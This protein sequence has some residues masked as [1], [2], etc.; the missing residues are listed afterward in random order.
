MFHILTPF[1]RK[2]NLNFYLKNLQTKNIIWH[3]ITH[4]SIVSFECNSWI[5]PFHIDFSLLPQNDPNYFKLNYFI[6]NGIIIDDDWYCFLNDD[7]WMEGNVI[8]EINKINDYDV[9]FCSMRRGDRIPNSKDVQPHGTETLIAKKGVGCGSIGLE[10]IFIKGKIL[11]QIKFNASS[12]I[13]YMSDGV[14]AEELQN[15]YEVKYIDNI[16]ML[17]NYLEPGRW[18]VMNE[19]AI[20]ERF[21]RSKHEFRDISEHLDTLKRYADECKTIVELGVNEG[22]STTAWAL[23]LKENP[24]D[25]FV[26]CF[27]YIGPQTY[28]Q[29]LLEMCKVNNL[30]LEFTLADDLKIEIPECDLL[31]CDTLHEGQQ[32]RQELKLHA[33]K[34][35]KYIIF[36]DTESFRFH[37]VREG[38]EGLWPTVEDFLKENSDKWFLKEHYSNCNGLTI[39]ER[40]ESNTNIIKDVEVIFAKV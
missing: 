8:N 39:L 32:L 40:I 37:G 19:N 38:S 11:K 25:R 5:I 6:E 26:Y 36:H 18:N 33:N 31:F 30:N 21:E 27:D 4:E 2:E 22:I 24:V 29:P 10:Q 23:S 12:E 3:P 20:R 34:A 28:L 17:F 9:V 16:F 1:S 14:L 15:K 35:R 7:D 13:Q